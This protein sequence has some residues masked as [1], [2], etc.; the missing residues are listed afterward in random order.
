MNSPNLEAHPKNGGAF[1]DTMLL[2]EIMKEKKQAEMK[3]MK[4]KLLFQFY[5]FIKVFF[6]IG[7]RLFLK[8][9]L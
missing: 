9:V 4:V 6:L 1:E 7:I 5:Y 3:Q 2:L 8:G